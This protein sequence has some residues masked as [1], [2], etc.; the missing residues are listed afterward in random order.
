MDTSDTP[1]P[2]ILPAAAPELIPP[3]LPEWDPLPPIIPP[4]D[5]PNLEP[6][7]GMGEDYGPGPGIPPDYPGEI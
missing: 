1:S 5:Y 7:P 3:T 4:P 2:E 6:E